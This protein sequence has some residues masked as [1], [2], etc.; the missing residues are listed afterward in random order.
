[1]ADSRDDRT[2]DRE[3]AVIHTLFRAIGRRLGTE[4]RLSVRTR[5]SSEGD[6]FG[7]P[8]CEAPFDQPRPS[9]DS[10]ERS[11]GDCGRLS[12]L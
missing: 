4:S 1:M 9:S 12:R 11:Q 8:E 3:E 10:R 2:E 7:D 6:L 5:D